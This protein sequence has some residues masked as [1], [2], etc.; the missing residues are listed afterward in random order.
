TRFRKTLVRGLGLLSD[1]TATLHAGDMLDGETAFKLYDTYGFPLDLTQD[2]LRQRSISV[3]IA[4]FTDAMERQKAE[5][6]AHWAGSGEAATEAV[7]FSVREKT[8]ATE[9]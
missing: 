3:D 8:G 5:A 1:A 4:G 6:R 7:W 9:F 2:A